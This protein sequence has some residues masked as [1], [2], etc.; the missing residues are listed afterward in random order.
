MLFSGSFSLSAAQYQSQ[1]TTDEGREN[2]LETPYFWF[3]AHGP[4]HPDRLNVPDRP[5]SFSTSR[6]EEI[7]MVRSTALHMS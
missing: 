7:S 1:T 6:I 3:V 5:P 2:E 4:S